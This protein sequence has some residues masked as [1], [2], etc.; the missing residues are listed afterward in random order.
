MFANTL[1]K[2]SGGYNLEYTCKNIG[3][4]E[5]SKIMK[6]MP[7]FFRTLTTLYDVITTQKSPCAPIMAD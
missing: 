1:E 3:S 2:I 5:L 6:I 4:H 7:Y